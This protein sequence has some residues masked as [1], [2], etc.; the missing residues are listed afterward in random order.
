MQNEPPKKLTL[1]ETNGLPLKIGL[2]NRK[3]V[4][5]LSIFRGYVSFKEISRRVLLSYDIGCFI[6]ILK[7]VYC[8]PHA[9]NWIVRHPSQNALYTTVWGRFFHC[10]NDEKFFKICCQTLGNFSS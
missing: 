5:Q 9:Q 3:I 1:P 6:G 8:N 10:S 4:F 7:V 2:P